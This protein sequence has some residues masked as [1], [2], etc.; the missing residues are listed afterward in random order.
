MYNVYIF[1]YEAF[2]QNHQ[3]N[4]EWHTIP[5]YCPQKGTDSPSPSRIRLDHVLLLRRSALLRWKYSI[6]GSST[7]AESHERVTLCLRLMDG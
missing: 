7:G 5:M 1:V 4:L 2:S 3:N 6:C